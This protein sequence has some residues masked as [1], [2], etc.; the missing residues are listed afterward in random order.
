MEQTAI[1]L[2]SILTS[3]E[4]PSLLGSNHDNDDFNSYQQSSA[5]R[6]A[7]RIVIEDT[8]TPA[9]V[10]KKQQTHVRNRVNPSQL[11]ELT[12]RVRVIPNTPSV[13]SNFTPKSTGKVKNIS[14]I[15]THIFVVLLNEKLMF[16][17]AFQITASLESFSIR[18]ICSTM[19]MNCPVWTR[20]EP[21]LRVCPKWPKCPTILNPRLC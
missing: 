19:R 13:R 9:L 7:S 17:Y 8:P 21:T 1:S 10:R 15:Y 16:N 18:M 2:T 12:N 6:Q 4:S 11:D 5:R 3:Q 20:T 14:R